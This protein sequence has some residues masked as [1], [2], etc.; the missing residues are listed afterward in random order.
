MILPALQVRSDTKPYSPTEGLLAHLIP[1]AISSLLY[2]NYLPLSIICIFTVYRRKRAGY[3]YQIIAMS[4]LV[5]ASTVSLIVQWVTQSRAFR[6]LEAALKTASGGADTTQI[7]QNSMAKTLLDDYTVLGIYIFS[8]VIADGLLMYRCYVIWN[9]DLKV[10][11]IP[12][13]G[14]LSNIV[15]GILSIV[16]DHNLVNDFWIITVLENITLTLL[17]AGRILYINK[18]IGGILGSAVKTKYNTIAAV[19]LESGFLYSSIVLATSITARIPRNA[20]YASCL[21]AASTQIVG[22]APSLIII[23]VARGVDTRDILSSIAIMTSSSNTRTVPHRSGTGSRSVARQPTVEIPRNEFSTNISHNDIW[24]TEAL[25]Q[26]S[27]LNSGERRKMSRIIQT[28]MQKQRPGREY[29]PIIQDN[30]HEDD[31]DSVHDSPT[32]SDP[33]TPTPG[34]TPNAQKVEFARSDLMMLGSQVGM[35]VETDKSPVEKEN[36]TDFT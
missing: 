22:I 27:N 13:L 18:E 7:V 8:N 28:Q 9:R 17:T 32:R 4:L 24:D 31:S 20:I 16:H 36:T 11:V 34:P 19:M 6:D 23:R 30:D 2:A 35:G 29:A 21:L 14:Y 3:Q 15:L 26:N 33:N 12:A 25:L 10:V 5:L 1:S